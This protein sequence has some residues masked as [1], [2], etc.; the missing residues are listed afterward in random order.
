MPDWRL[1]FLVR[2]ASYDNRTL[3]LLLLKLLRCCHVTE[4]RNLLSFERD[5]TFHRLSNSGG[6]ILPSKMIIFQI[7]KVF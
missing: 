3:H 7:E 2:R 1:D 4:I 5:L 6:Y